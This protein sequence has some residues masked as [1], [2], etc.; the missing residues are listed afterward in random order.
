MDALSATPLTETLEEATGITKAL[1]DVA[2]VLP[3]VTSTE[4]TDVAK[5]FPPVVTLPNRRNP[6]LQRSVRAGLT[7]PVGRIHRK[8]KQKFHGPITE[9]SS[10]YLTGVLEYMAREVLEA[11]GESA[12]AQKRKRVTGRNLYLGFQND[13]DLRHLY[14]GMNIII[15]GGGVVPQPLQKAKKITVA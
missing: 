8:L 2:E 4:A 14:Q 15:P 9:S 12:H 11:A 7:F 5:A 6:P 10:V 3:D 1:P 13:V